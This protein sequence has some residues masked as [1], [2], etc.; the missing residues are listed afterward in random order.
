MFYIGSLIYKVWKSY[1]RQ[2]GSD[3]VAVADLH[4]I[5]CWV[6]G[7]DLGEIQAKIQYGFENDEK[8]LTVSCEM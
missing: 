5:S 8:L 7:P 6:K 3:C 1:K 2:Q 4:C